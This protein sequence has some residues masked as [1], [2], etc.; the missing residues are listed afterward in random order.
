MDEQTP[1]ENASDGNLAP[2]PAPPWEGVTIADLRDFDFET[3]IAGSKSAD[4]GELGDVYRAA[5]A[6]LAPD[7]AANG[8]ASRIFSMLAAVLGMH[9]DRRSPPR[10]TTQLSAVTIRH[11]VSTNTL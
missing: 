8:P 1:P 3:P 7:A 5:A 9:L 10:R 6:N 11:N 4:A 2:Q